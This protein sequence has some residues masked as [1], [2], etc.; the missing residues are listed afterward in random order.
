MGLSPLAATG[1]SVRTAIRNAWALTFGDGIE[2]RHATPHE[3][4]YDAPHRT[5]RRYLAG[6]EKS[7]DAGAT[8][9]LLVPPLAVSAACYDLRPGQS[10]VAHL[11]EQGYAPYVIDYGDITFAD[12]RM[13]FEEWVQDIVPTALRRVSEE[14]GGAL[15]HVV[16]WSLGG[17]ISF[18]TAGADPDLPIASITALGTPFDYSRIAPIELARRVGKVTG[19]RVLALPTAAMGGVPRHLVR[20]GFKATALQRELTKPLYVLGNLTDTEALARM[21]SVDRFMAEMP[22]YPGRF[23]LQVY[24]RLIQRLELARGLVR[25]NDDLHVD[26]TRV[27][28]PVQIIGSSTDAIAPAPAVAAGAQVFT[29]AHSVRYV[30]VT[31]SHLG[32]V[33]GVEAPRVTWPLVTGFLAEHQPVPA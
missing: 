25:L 29:G 33:A 19:G 13:G 7:H 24:A 14:H 31:G 2:P 22:G 20:A 5:L 28:P 18:L 3:V 9:V 32:L 1:P 21:Q 4:L 8:P 10:L 23:Y 30:E 15:V 17:T 26:L 16:A 11:L 27:R 6:D 12:R